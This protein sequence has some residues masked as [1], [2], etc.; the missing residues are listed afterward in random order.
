MRLVAEVA[1]VEDACEQARQ[2]SQEDGEWGRFNVCQDGIPVAEVV[3]HKFGDA[4]QSIVTYD[5]VSERKADVDVMAR[6][7][8][9]VEVD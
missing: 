2:S 4:Y 3:T 5:R 7:D 8:D 1:T 6:F 9:P